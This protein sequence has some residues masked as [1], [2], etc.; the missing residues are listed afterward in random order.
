V[1]GGKLVFAGLQERLGIRSVPVTNTRFSM[2]DSG[3]FPYDEEEMRLLREEIEE[4]YTGFIRRVAGGR[5]MSVEAV[6]NV[7]QGRIWSG[8]DALEHGLVDGNLG[9]LEVVEEAAR[10]A[11]LMPDRYRIV[12]LP[13]DVRSMLSGLV[14]GL[15]SA[16]T[17]LSAPEWFAPF[18]SGRILAMPPY[19]LDAGQAR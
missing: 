9:F 4:F 3:A 10:L 17:L 13:L 5:G 8:L 19:M 15:A 14:P 7:A 16:E 1:F 18:S 12:A 11:G 2:A 6:D